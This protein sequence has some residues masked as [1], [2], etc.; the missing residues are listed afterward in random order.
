MYKFG[1]IC[2]GI[3]WAPQSMFPQPQ[4]QWNQ[5]HL[6]ACLEMQIWG[7]TQIS[8]ISISKRGQEVCV[9]TNSPGDPYAC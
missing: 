6:G 4:Y 5:H 3:V 7:P 9:L 1:L 8:S 2:E